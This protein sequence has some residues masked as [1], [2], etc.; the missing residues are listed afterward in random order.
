MGFSLLQ[1]K[2]CNSQNNFITRS[3]INNKQKLNIEKLEQKKEMFDGKINIFKHE[4]NTIAKKVDFAK[5]EW[6]HNNG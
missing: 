6:L 3:N 5:Y 2:V 1:L 4:F